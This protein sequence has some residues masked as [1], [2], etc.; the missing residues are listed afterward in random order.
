ML[1]ILAMPSKYENLSDNGIAW[2]VEQIVTEPLPNFVDESIVL[3][4]SYAVRC[5]YKNK[6]LPTRIAQL[7]NPIEEMRQQENLVSALEQFGPD[8]ISTLERAR[9]LVSRKWNVHITEKEV[10]EVLIYMACRT[11]NPGQWN[12]ANFVDAL[13]AE[14]NLAP[15]FD[16]EVVLD[17]LDREDFIVRDMDGVM[18]VI[19]AIQAGTKG[20]RDF[21]IA[22]WGRQWQYP[23]SQWSVL[24]AYLQPQTDVRTLPGLRKIFTS[25]DFE[26]ANSHVK[27]MVT[28][29]E[30]NKL[31][32]YDAIDA[33]LHLSFDNTVP[34]DIHQ[35]AQ[36]QLESA[37]KF[38]PELVLC[39]A[40]QKPQPWTLEV[41]DLVGQ[42]FDIFFEGHT[43]YQLI[44]HRLWNLDRPMVARRF[45]D[46][47]NRSRL[48]ITRI[49]DISQ[50]L[51]CL[52]D[53]L[54]IPDAQFVLDIATLAARREYLNLEKWLQGMLSKYGA[55][56]WHECYR[57]LRIKA[58]AEYEHAREGVKQTHVSLRVGP[59]YTM[60]TVLDERYELTP[61]T[62]KIMLIM[63]IAE[64]AKLKR[65]KNKSPRP[66]VFVSKRTL[67]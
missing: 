20:Q 25:D 41:N 59:V 2:F 56:F 50:D 43:S 53:L 13:I 57:F 1:E 64:F 18:V 32:S 19:R 21:P 27:A 40:L 16:W 7:T 47:Y 55:E 65:F 4:L 8:S 29:L 15:T 22:F 24:S 23:R 62:G 66:S 30:G 44:F 9:E 46:Y 51:R 34:Q 45:I 33:L 6:A 38:A 26:T 60:L 12:S 11:Q 58:A 31:I 28:I 5:R 61:Y 52:G 17:N 67:A 39:G 42:L 48:N 49:M 35:A 54:E 36:R 63:Y 37:C 14:G 10:A 3:R